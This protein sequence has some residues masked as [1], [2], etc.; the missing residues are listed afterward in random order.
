MHTYANDPKWSTGGEEEGEKW[1]CSK[2]EGKK[3]MKTIK[4]QDIVDQEYPYEIHWFI[5]TTNIH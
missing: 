4:G 3:G 2:E 5:F 1:T